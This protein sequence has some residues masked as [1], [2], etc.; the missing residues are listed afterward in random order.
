MSV[1][2]SDSDNVF[3]ELVVVIGG[4]MGSPVFCDGA[5]PSIRFCKSSSR[6][7]IRASSSLCTLDSV[8]EACSKVSLGWPR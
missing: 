1:P 7:R 8:A 4:E 5:G 6:F 3:V 2:R